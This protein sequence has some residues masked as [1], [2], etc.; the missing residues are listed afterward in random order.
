MTLDGLTDRF[1]VLNV[2]LGGPVF[3]VAKLDWLNARYIRELEPG[4]LFERVRAW[5][6]GRARLERIIELAQP[7]I[8]RLSDLA[9]L[10]AFLFAGRLGPAKERLLDTKL[11]ADEV[12]RALA[13]ALWGLDAE[14]EFDR[15]AIEHVL[16]SVAEVLG[17]KFRDLARVY[18]VALTGSPTSVPLFDA[19]ELLGRDIVRERLRLALELVGLPSAAEQKAWRVTL[20]AEEI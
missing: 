15:A 11:P 7:R 17:R 1:D 20:P 18:Y 10:T 14:R 6:F 16:K 5:G 8:E 2:S 3:D 4:A 13:L 19:M 9:E 12:R